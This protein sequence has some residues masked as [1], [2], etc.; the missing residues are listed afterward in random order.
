MRKGV[1][2]STSKQNSNPKPPFFNICIMCLIS[3]STSSFS[4][5][6]SCASCNHHQLLSLRSLPFF[7][8][9][10]CFSLL[11]FASS[12]H[13]L[14]FS[15]SSYFPSSRPIFCSSLLIDYKCILHLPLVLLLVFRCPFLNIILFPLLFF[16]GGG[17]FLLFLLSFFFL[18]W[19]HVNLP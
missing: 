15:F 3:W 6:S 7:S 19:P 16:G 12:S 11:P 10:T 1:S 9:I 18:L 8:Q 17:Y 4:N 5:V 13:R 14:I 2:P